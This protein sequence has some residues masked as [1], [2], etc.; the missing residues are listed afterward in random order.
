MWLLYARSPVP[1]ARLWPG[2]RWL[3]LVDALVWP[4][5]VAVLVTQATL[6]IGLF[7][8]VILALCALLAVRRCVR[9]VWRNERYRFTTWR[10]GRVAAPLLVVGVVMRLMLTSA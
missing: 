3:A 4:G 5:L 2:R 6:D 7:A 1:D 10:W 9:A 8:P